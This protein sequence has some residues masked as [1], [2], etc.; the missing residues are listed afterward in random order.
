MSLQDRAER[1]LNRGAE[2]Y[3]RG[4]AREARQ[5]FTEALAI[6]RRLNDTEG[7]LAAIG[8]DGPHSR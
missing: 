7:K 8:N 6:F 5:L 3:R 1:L 2:Q 4:N